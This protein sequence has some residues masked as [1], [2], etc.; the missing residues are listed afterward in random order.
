MWYNALIHGSNAMPK[1]IK[2]AE[3]KLTELVAIAKELSGMTIV[4]DGELGTC[5]HCYERSY[6]RHRPTCPVV[7]LKNFLE[8]L[9]S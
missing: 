3:A 5:I 2:N 8:T 6:R 1:K 4:Y 7:K 9:E